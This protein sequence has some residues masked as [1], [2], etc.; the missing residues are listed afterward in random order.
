MWGAFAT[1]YL[2]SS[3][4]PIGLGSTKPA[5]TGATSCV[6]VHIQNE[7]G[8]NELVFT[9]EPEVDTATLHYHLVDLPPHCV[10]FYLLGISSSAQGVYFIVT[11]AAAELITVTR[12]ERRRWG[13][14]R[15]VT[16]AAAG[17]ARQMGRR[18]S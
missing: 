2:T 8:P 11:M 4:R 12:P 9:I 16:S 17:N 13:R 1:L 6:C 15:A 5:S 10:T 14:E 18:P 7:T 3:A